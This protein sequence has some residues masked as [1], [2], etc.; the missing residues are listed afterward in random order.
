MHLRGGTAPS[1]YYLGLSGAASTDRAHPLPPRADQDGYRPPLGRPV[2]PEDGVS[3]CRRIH[4][5]ARDRESHE[6]PACC[7]P[8][9]IST[10]FKFEDVNGLNAL[11]RARLVPDAIAS[12]EFAGDFG[13]PSQIQSAEKLNM[14]QFGPQPDAA[15]RNSTRGAAQ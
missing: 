10:I 6:W 13:W 1:P 12:S 14:T 5:I 9:S 3:A 7:C 8:R 2:G 4:T 11:A 15:Q